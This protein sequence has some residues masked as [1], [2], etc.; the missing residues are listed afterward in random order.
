MKIWKFGYTYGIRCINV[1]GGIDYSA[2]FTRDFLKYFAKKYDIRIL[3]LS[4]NGG[5]HALEPR[6]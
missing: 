3:E 1:P 4:R 2:C 5:G 6:D